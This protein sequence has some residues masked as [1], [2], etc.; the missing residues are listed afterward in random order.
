MQNKLKVNYEFL[1]IKNY[2]HIPNTDNDYFDLDRNFNLSKKFQGEKSSS[3][4]VVI[5]ETTINNKTIKL[6]SPKLDI[7]EDTLRIKLYLKGF[8][9]IW[10]DKNFISYYY[11][12]DFLN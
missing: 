2:R 8:V 11:E 5:Y 4:C 1:M 10:H 6:I 12:L 3:Y 9:Y 7:D